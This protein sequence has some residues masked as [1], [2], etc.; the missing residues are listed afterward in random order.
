MRHGKSVMK[1]LAAAVLMVIMCC[2]P[3]LAAEQLGATEEAHWDSS[4]TGVARWKKVDK[5]REYQV[6][7]YVNGDIHVKTLT[8]TGTKAD[9]SSYMDDGSWYN[10]SVRA[11]PKSGQKKYS[12]GEWVES[13]EYQA[14]GLGDT[15]GR[16]RTF[17][18]GKK[19]QKE[20]GNYVT[21]QWYLVQSSWYYFN[22]EGFAQ[23]GWQ[24]LDS[25]WYYLNEEGVMQT[26][27]L[28]SNGSRYFLDQ[29]GAMV[30]GWKQ[31][32]PGEWYYLDSEGK[33]LTNTEIDGYRLNEAGMWVQ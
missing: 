18:Q 20:D 33:M 8:V 19:Y 29:D 22:Q 2:M 1:I 4:Q 11:V 24:Q 32:N 27:W 6:R 13:D 31:V 30:T 10:F 26:G 16:W 9:F 17:S 28:D 21:D 14:T 5:A 3:A 12:A 7:L 25:R 23:T 15:R